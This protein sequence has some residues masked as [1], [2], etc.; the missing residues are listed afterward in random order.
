MG[1]LLLI[2]SSVRNRCYSLTTTQLRTP[3]TRH[4]AVPVFV[5]KQSNTYT[6]FLLHHW[7]I[8]LNSPSIDKLSAHMYL[9]TARS[10]VGSQQSQGKSPLQP[11][12]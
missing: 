9:I 6:P 3:L 1:L 12:P 11:R 5:S 4:K 10:Y 2:L 8:A 7:N